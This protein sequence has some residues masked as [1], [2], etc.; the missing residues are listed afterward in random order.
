MPLHIVTALEAAFPGVGGLRVA[1]GLGQIQRTQEPGI[2]LI[3]PIVV[4]V[5]PA[6]MPADVE[7][8]KLRTGG[9]RGLISGRLDR[10][11]CRHRGPRD[12]SP[13]SDARNQKFPHDNSPNLS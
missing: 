9:W 11:V 7:P 6:G 1:S 5:L 4:V 2:V 13:K 8:T 12:Q 3:L 10:Q